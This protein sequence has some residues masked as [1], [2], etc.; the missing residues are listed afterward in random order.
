MDKSEDIA[1]LSKILSSCQSFNQKTFKNCVSIKNSPSFLFHNIDGNKSNFDN[2]VCEITQYCHL[3]SFI[4]ISETNVD[5]CHKDLYKITG[6]VPD[7][8]DKYNKSKGSGVALY[9]K[10]EYN[11]IRLEKFCPG[12]LKI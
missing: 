3:F 2:F 6:Y 1:E 10:E 5:P 12:V 7:Y 11:F 4:G 9:V 8:N